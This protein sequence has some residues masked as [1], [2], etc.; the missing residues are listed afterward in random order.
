MFRTLK[1]D[2]VVD[3]QCVKDFKNRAIP[4]EVAVLSLDQNFTG[5]WIVPPNS[6]ITTLCQEVREENDW[7]SQNYHVLDWLDQGA[8]AKVLFKNLEEIC[9]GT[10]VGIYQLKNKPTLF[11]NYFTALRSNFS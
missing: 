4:K 1:M 11:G 2:I 6:K 3:I 7:L 9:G 5:H 10:K 8:S